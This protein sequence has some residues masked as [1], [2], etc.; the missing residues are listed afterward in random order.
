MYLGVIIDDGLTWH[1]HVEHIERKTAQTIAQLWRHGKSLSLKARRTWYISMIQARLCYASNCFFPAL[2]AYLLNRLVKMAKAGVRATLLQRT[3]VPT[4][5]LLEILGV[6]PLNYVYTQ[7]VCLFVHRCLHS[8]ASPLFQHFF[9]T[10][11]CA[12]AI[13]AER[14]VTRGHES[15]LL[16]VPF[17][18]GVA[19]RSSLPF[20]G[21]TLWNSLP[22]DIRCT[23]TTSSFKLK[24]KD[25]DLLALTP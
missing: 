7:K 15:L 22:E 21:S 11:Q 6:Q 3:L 4:A 2:S 5:P 1:P 8:A 18:R 16:V 14:R 13:T 25:V 19:G 17:L 12:A 9:T 10:F 20:R 24:L 23:H